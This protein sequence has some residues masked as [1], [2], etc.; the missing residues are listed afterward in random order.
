MLQKH[1]QVLIL[2]MGL[3][4]VY[5]V[6]PFLCAT[7]EQKFCHDGPQG[8]LSAKT[9]THVTCCQ[10]TKT[11]T[12]DETETPS[13]SDKPCCATDFELVL[14]DNR[15]NIPEFRKLI[16][17]SLISILPTSATLPVDSQESF[18][19]SSAL[20]VSTLFPDHPLSRRG[21]PFTQ[22]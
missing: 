21:P 16:G 20:V 1:R 6:C 14:P 22:R 15:D 5:S 19:I 2:L 17:Q 13:E 8:V 11:N 3:L 12:A 9:E 10:N 7:F 18:K 4:Y